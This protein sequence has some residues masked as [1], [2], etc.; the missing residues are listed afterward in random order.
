MNQVSI[1]IKQNVKKIHWRIGANY[2]KAD[3]RVYFP[4]LFRHYIFIKL[5]LLDKKKQIIKKK[6]MN[7]LFYV[8]LKL[9]LLS[10]YIYK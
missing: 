5:S 1:I 8:Y 10:L 6:S 3:V 9:N 4:N 2:K 7:L